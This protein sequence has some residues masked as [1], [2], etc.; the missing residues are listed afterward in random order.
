M[1]FVVVVWLLLVPPEFRDVTVAVMI[2]NS[3]DKEL[4]AWCSPG[5]VYGDEGEI[6]GEMP[7]EGASAE[8]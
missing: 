8:K 3:E 1:V 5:D 7:V 2:G 6:A 4:F